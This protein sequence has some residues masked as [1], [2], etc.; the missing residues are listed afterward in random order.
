MERKPQQ[1]AAKGGRETGEDGRTAVRL[2]QRLNDHEGGHREEH[3]RRQRV[4][5]SAESAFFQNEHARHG[6]CRTKGQAG[7][8]IVNQGLELAEPYEAE[9]KSGLKRE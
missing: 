1:G 3:D 9:C 2:D 6:E 7:L 8:S 4:Q 5:S